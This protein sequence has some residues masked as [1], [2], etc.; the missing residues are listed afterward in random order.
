MK[1]MGSKRWMLGNGLGELLDR[2]VPQNA[3]FVDLMCGSGAVSSFV[4]TRHRIEVLATDL[5]HFSA[6]LTAATIERTSAIDVSRVWTPWYLEAKKRIEA[7]DS[8]PSAQVVTR[9]FVI[10]ARRWC[11]SRRNKP[12][13]RAYGGH[14]FSPLQ[15]MWFAS[16]LDTLPKEASV[17]KVALAAV[18]Q[19]AS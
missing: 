17:H 4:A 16:F 7:V 9:A 13:V 5:Q 18:I 19:A 3:R 8:I 1:Y 14:Y 6:C 10:R 11:A 15:A 2:V 12:I